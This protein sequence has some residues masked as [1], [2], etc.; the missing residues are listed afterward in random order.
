MKLSVAARLLA[1]AIPSLPEKISG[2]VIPTTSHQKLHDGDLV[3]VAP[4]AS[5]QRYNKRGG[6]HK[7]TR[8]VR[9]LNKALTNPSPVPSFQV[10]CDPTSAD[11][12]TGILSCGEDHICQPSSSYEIGGI[13]VPMASSNEPIARRHARVGSLARKHPLMNIPP[14]EVQQEPLIP[15]DP[16]SIDLGVLACGYGEFCR[17][18]DSSALGGFCMDTSATSRGL[19]TLND[20]IGFCDPALEEYSSD[21]D[22]SDLNA[23]SGTGTM[24]CTPENPGFVYGCDDL[25]LNNPYWIT[26]ED[27]VLFKVKDCYE[28]K[29]PYNLTFCTTAYG[30]NLDESCALQWNGQDCNSCVLNDYFYDFNCSNVDEGTAG[31]SVVEFSPIFAQC[32]KR[33]NYT[34]TNLCGEGSDI[35]Y[36]NFDINVT[37]PGVKLSC[38][39]LAYLEESALIPDYQC[40][41]AIA[42]AQSGCCEPSNSTMPDRPGLDEEVE[43]PNVDDS[44]SVGHF[45][46][47]T[48][49]A[50]AAI[51]FASSS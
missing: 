10:F 21:C 51:V 22:C 39:Y 14:A 7:R 25:I 23:T 45:M 20:W 38:G 19:V 33:A 11:A 16:I 50:A 5:F 41:D 3:E 26:F 32:Y 18:D 31:S 37:Y 34:C 17:R 9:Q 49:L 30:E 4:Q 29:E 42:V 15:C 40:P 47:M 8:L 36:L 24:Y 12:D 6:L 2:R 48:S 27:S 13:C 43:T 1:Q 46:S 44:A 28:I 35:P